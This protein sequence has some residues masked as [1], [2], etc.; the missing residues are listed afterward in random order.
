MSQLTQNQQLIPAGFTPCLVEMHR[1]AFSKKIQFSEIGA[2]DTLD[3]RVVSSGA[4]LIIGE[5]IPKWF[6]TPITQATAIL[7]AYCFQFGKRVWLIP[8]NKF[9]EVTKEL[10]QCKKTFLFNKTKLKFGYTD[11]IEQHAQACDMNPDLPSN[12][13]DLIREQHYPW[14]Y[15][16]SKLQFDFTMNVDI[17]QE[18]AKDFLDDVAKEASDHLK[19]IMGTAKENKAFPKISKKNVNRLLIFKDRMK[20][21]LILE[22]KAQYVIDVI[23]EFISTCGMPFGKLEVKKLISVL[24]FM[25]NKDLFLSMAEFESLNDDRKPY[26]LEKL[27]IN[28]TSSIQLN[29]N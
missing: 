9:D 14:S 7:E 13:G 29:I 6:K 5:N 10:Q 21:V 15:V 27:Q 19:Q 12:F 20:S 3:K 28:L 25:A 11:F 18:M 8:D 24:H 26:T 22:P 16:E 4:K 1:T 2:E 23:D 17:K